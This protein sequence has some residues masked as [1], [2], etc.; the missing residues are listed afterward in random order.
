MQSLNHAKGNITVLHPVGM[1]STITEEME[2]VKLEMV[3]TE[4]EEDPIH[5]TL[6]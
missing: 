1:E 4:V 3:D 6:V 2:D 5:V